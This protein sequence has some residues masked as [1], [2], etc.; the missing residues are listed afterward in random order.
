MQV[1][2]SKNEELD[3]VLDDAGPP[4][5]LLPALASMLIELAE[6]EAT[7]ATVAA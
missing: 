5:N 2:S 3:F 7:K 4:G 1:E 6:R